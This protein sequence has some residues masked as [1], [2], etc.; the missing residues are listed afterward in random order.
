MVEPCARWIMVKMSDYKDLLVW[1]K[2]MD[3][4]QR[5]YA[6]TKAFPKDELYGLTSQ[7]RR[8]AVSIPSNIAEGSNRSSKK[9]FKYFLHISL[10]SAAE[11]E[12]QLLLA[13]RIGCARDIETL[14]LE[15]TSIRKMINSLIRTLKD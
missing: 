4:A 15:I 14:L 1:Q 12:T 5:V 3:L 13:Q 9:E 11:L 10:G 2:S 8:C 7:V 6:I